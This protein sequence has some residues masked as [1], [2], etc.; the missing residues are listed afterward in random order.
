MIWWFL[1][2]GVF[3]WWMGVRIGAAFDALEGSITGK[4]TGAPRAGA[5]GMGVQ[6]PHVNASSTRAR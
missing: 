6:T 3:C 5:G 1:V 2:F 4:Q